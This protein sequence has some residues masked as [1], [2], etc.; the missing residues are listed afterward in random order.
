V[1]EA[2][3]QRDI[4]AKLGE[5]KLPFF[6]YQVGTFIAP[7]G[8]M[9]K[10]G[11]EGVSDLIGI[12]PYTVRPEDVGRTIGVFAA[13]EVKRPKG[14]VRKAQGP[15]LRTINRLGGIGAVVRSSEDAAA[16]VTGMWECELVK[17]YTDASSSL[18][19]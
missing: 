15:F 9:V 17:T 12:I 10:I 6:R 2:Q 11:V 13:L 5:L 8:S 18:G 19:G 3:I 4:R 1:K 7:D 16:V 14:A